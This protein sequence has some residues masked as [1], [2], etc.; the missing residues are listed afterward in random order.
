[1][2]KP[3]VLLKIWKIFSK[4]KFLSNLIAL[5]VEEWHMIIGDGIAK[6]LNQEPGDEERGSCDRAE[7]WERRVWGG[8]NSARGTV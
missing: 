2:H 8:G 4:I 3:L 6:E 5:K 1:M 7:E